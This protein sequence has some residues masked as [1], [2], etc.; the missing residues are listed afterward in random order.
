MLCFPEVETDVFPRYSY[1]SRV[2]IGPKLF[3]CF[4]YVL[5][6]IKLNLD[7]FLAL[8]LH[9]QLNVSIWLPQITTK[10]QNI[11]MEPIICTTKSLFFYPFLI[12]ANVF[13]MYPITASRNLDFFSFL[14]SF[15]QR[16]WFTYH[17]CSMTILFYSISLDNIPFNKNDNDNKREL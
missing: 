4:L 8:G 5:L 15:S 9:I 16:F 13:R 3:L 1:T 12:L 2:G 7:F 6:I 14:H 10:S 17:F 11:T